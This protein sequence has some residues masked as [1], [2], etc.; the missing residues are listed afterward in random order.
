VKEIATGICASPAARTIPIASFVYVSVSALTKSA[1]VLANVWIWDRWYA[2]A[3][4]A[5]ICS[6]GL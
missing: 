6:L 1:A 5:L 2:S 3:S 4:P